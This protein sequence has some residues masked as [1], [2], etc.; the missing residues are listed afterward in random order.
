M[1]IKKYQAE[2]YDNS[3]Y[4][5]GE[6]PVY[7]P[8][9][10]RLSW[11]DIIAN[12]LYIKDRDGTRT[13]FDLGQ[14]VGA[15]IPVKDSEDFILA[16]RDGLYLYERKK[17]AADIILNM[18]GIYKDYWRSND[19]KADP[20][21]RIFVGATS[22]DDKRPDEGNLYVVDSG[23]RIAQA[24]T[25]ISNGMAWSGDNGTFYFSDSSEHAVFAYDYDIKT[26]DICNRRVL[27]EVENGVPDGMCIDED[28]NIWLAVWGG[29]RVEKR[30]GKTGELLATVDVAAEHT[31]CCCFGG[32]DMSTLFITSSGIDLNG[33]YD[34]CIFT[35][36][37]DSKGTCPYY[38]DLTKIER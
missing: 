3:K 8:R 13:C 9:Y 19:A 4:S 38:S 20:Y 6:G 32:E 18:S 34:G 25:K 5:L 29:S 16:G 11:V 30:D 14:P 1:I 17:N 10:G 7:D 22:E 28:D 12:K 27:F 24:D 21:G 33:K 2:V 36:K 37:T 31:S 26:G 23:V 15:A 35:C